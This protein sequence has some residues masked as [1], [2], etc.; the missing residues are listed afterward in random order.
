MCE[1]VCNRD[2]HYQGL[3]NKM[4]YRAL[5]SLSDRCNPFTFHPLVDLFIPTPTQLLWEAFSHAAIIAQ[6]FA[7]LTTVN[8]QVLIYTAESTGASKGKTKMPNLRNGSKRNSKPGS[9]ACESGNLP[10]GYRAPHII[11]T[12][13]IYQVLIWASQ[14]YG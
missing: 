13:A 6:I 3:S 1:G 9:L 10:L 12:I 14:I 8:S 4:C 11:N 2:T 7:Y 5:S